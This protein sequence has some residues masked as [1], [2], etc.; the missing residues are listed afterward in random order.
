MDSTEH[1]YIYILYLHMHTS[2]K[3]NHKVKAS[4]KFRKTLENLGKS[5]QLQAIYLM[6][7]ARFQDGLY[8]CEATEQ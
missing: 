8:Q 2:W 4:R 5:L 6:R 3:M 1:A 7:G